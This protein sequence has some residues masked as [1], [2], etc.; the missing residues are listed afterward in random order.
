MSAIPNGWVQSQL[1]EL[2]EFA[3]GG[4]WG[5]D[6]NHHED[7]FVEVRCI[8]GTELRN[9][10]VDK[11]RSAVARKIKETSLER[12][13]LAKNDLIVEISGGGPD[14][15]V[16]RTVRIVDATL[17]QH[18]PT[19]V[20]CTNFFR[21]VT[22]ASPDV[23]P[24][25]ERFLGFDYAEGGT[26]GIQSGSNNLRN[27]KFSSFLEKKLPLPPLAE[28]Q[29]IVRKLDTLS[30]RTT[31]ARTDLTLI[32]TL[33]ERYKLNFLRSVFRGEQT[34]SFRD[35]NALEPVSALLERTE[36][37]EQGRGGRKPTAEIIPGKGGISVNNPGTALQEGWDWVPLLRLA[38][39]ETGHTPSRSHPEWW[40]GEV[41]WISIP[42]A[43]KHHG[44]LIYDTVQKTNEAG[45]ANSS[46]RLLPAGTVVLSRTASVGYVTILGR[47]MATSQDFATWTCNEALEPKFLMYA[48]LSEGNDIRGFGE[49]TTHTTIYFPEI[50]AFNIK[51]APLEEQRE[52][53][54]RI[55]AAFGM[56]ERLVGKAEKALTLTDRL[57]QR[58][59]AKAFSGEL[60]PQNPNDE[61]ASALLDHIREAQANAPK[62]QRKRRTK[63]NTMKKKPKDL[64][65]ED[66]ADW[67]KDGL[68]FEDVAKRVVLPHDDL[69]DALYDL[70]GGSNPK[71]EQVFDKTEER[72]RLKRVT[73]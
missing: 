1:S 64:L 35:N 37:P 8:R 42:D 14:Q 20:V 62:K 26:I 4:D 31:A 60:V 59:L 54:S 53:V 15:P 29:R 52:I 68:P 7:G 71:L 63:A 22:F 56:V 46:A 47:E 45:L 2:V 32:P 41:C 9:W 38:R 10:K 66:S 67:P 58:I 43:N 13:Q 48:L 25:I 21:R 50:R 61:P 51:L 3:I 40:G 17:D 30:S 6:I 72:M 55:E 12:R 65:L 27:L 33:V 18:A 49:G 23:A 39:Q 24:F 69:R 44:Q 70:L 28:Q 57:D 11:G 16:G 5:K 36:M 34:A 73:Q 19:P